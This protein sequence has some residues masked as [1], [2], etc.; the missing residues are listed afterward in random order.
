MNIMFHKGSRN[1]L[2]NANGLSATMVERVIERIQLAVPHLDFEPW[3]V[4]RK[5][6]EAQVGA[7]DT[8]PQ[9]RRLRV[10]F[11][12]EGLY[13][14]GHCYKVEKNVVSSEDHEF[15]KHLA[16]EA[17]EFLRQSGKVEGSLADFGSRAV[18]YSLE[19]THKLPKSPL[20]LFQ[21]LRGISQQ[22]YENQRISYGIII[23]SKDHFPKV[24]ESLVTAADNKRFKHLS[25]GY[26]T[27]FLVDG[28]GYLVGL[29][30]LPLAAN[31][32]EAARRRPSWLS[33]LAEI[34][35]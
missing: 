10:S 22:T 23:S 4:E 35:K 16:L 3:R 14:E 27:A 28:N 26:S 34:A 25:D 29:E 13:F 9:R 18:S 32:F 12:V 31:K 15:L 19:Q 21:F 6:D 1:R 7:F 11:I 20:P 5:T 2:R 8:T 24:K 30:A 17:Q 33:N